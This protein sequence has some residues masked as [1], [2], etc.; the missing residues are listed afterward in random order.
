MKIWVRCLPFFVVEFLARRFCEKV[1]VE[2]LS[3]FDCFNPFNDVV[4][5]LRKRK[6][7]V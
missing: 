5:A 7:N 2:G 6:N 4:L 3:E 1:N